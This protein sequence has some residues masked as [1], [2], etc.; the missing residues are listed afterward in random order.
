MR[1]LLL[2]AALLL[3]VS[4][5]PPQAVVVH[6][7][8]VIPGFT[9]ADAAVR[10]DAGQVA[11]AIAKSGKAPSY[12]KVSVTTMDG[13]AKAGVDY[14]PVASSVTFGNNQLSAAVPVAI[15]ARPGY[16]GDRSFTVHILVIR[17]GAV[18]RG[19]ATVTIHDSEQPPPP[20]PVQVWTKCADEGGVCT[21]VGS[22]NVRYGTPDMGWI[23]QLVTGSIS[24]T[25]TAWGNFPGS[26]KECDT[27]GT[28]VAPAPPPAPPPPPPPTPSPSGVITNWVPAPLIV[29]GYACNKLQLADARTPPCGQGI[30]YRVVGTV[31]NGAAGALLGSV[32]FTAQFAQDASG[33]FPLNDAYWASVITVWAPDQL[34]GIAPAP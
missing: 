15:I 3:Q 16:Q 22:A 34:Q 7:S 1:R 6:S 8:V 14:K 29:G 25:A 2:A 27:D 26:P 10:E 24:C 28:P 19:D 32:I 30:V 31:A 21:I 18:T 5:A 23:R 9:V 20:P 4:A 17:D 13:T 33:Q 11:V 12:S